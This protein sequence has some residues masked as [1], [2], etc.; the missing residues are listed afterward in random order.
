MAESLLFSVAESLVGKLA[1]TAVQKASEV[2]CVYDDV[3]GLKETVSFIKAV[4]LDAEQKPQKSNELRAWLR[5]I[6]R[7]F[8]DAEDII[9]DFECE[10][11]RK[12]V[13]NTYG[14]YTR[15]VRRFFSTSN[16]LVYRFRMAHHIKD[17]KKRLDKVAADRDKFGLQIKD[18]DTRVVHRRE[19]THSHV[20]ASDVIGREH[21]KEKIIELLLQDGT[22]A[23]S[24]SIIPIVGI[25]GLGKTTLAKL[26]FNDKIVDESFPLK[27]WVCV[28]D[29]FELEDMLRKIL[30]SAKDSSTPSSTLTRQESF[31]N[32]EMEQL[33]HLLTSKLAG[34]KFLLV[35]DD[36]WNED[37]VKWLKLKDLLQG[38]AEGSKVLVTT[39]SQSIAN[40]MGTNS[41]YGLQGLSEDDSLSLFVKWAFKEGE[42]TKY[43]ELLEIAKEIVEKCGGLPLAVRT[44]GS[45]LFLKVDKE[46]W[47]SV[48]DNEI[49]NLPS[50]EGDILP[51]LK[52]SYDQ[53]PS[54]LKPCF[55]CFSLCPKDYFFTDY[56]VTGLWE[57]L[58][59]LPSPNKN[60]T[61]ADVGIQILRELQSRSF[62]Q[63]FI[64]HGTFVQ[65]KLHDLVHDLTM[66]VAKDEFHRLNSCSQ[67]ISENARHLFFTKNDLLGQTSIPSGL[68]TIILPAGANNEAF[69]NTLVSRCKYLR[70]LN[71]SGSEYESLP[72][73]IGKLK[74]LRFLS[75]D[76]N[77]KLKRLPTSV[78]KLQNLQALYFGGCTKLKTLPRGIG[79]LISLR[80]LSVSTKQ[81]VFPDKEVAK[82]TSLEILTLSYCDNM[83]SLFQGVQLPTLRWLTIDSCG[84]LKS[85]PFHAT[86]NLESL[87][88]G[89]CSKL[90]MSK[91]LDNQIIELR[92]K[93]PHLCD[94]P[95]L[96][97]LPPWIQRYA[98]TLHSLNI[99]G[100]DNIKELPEWLPTLVC[101][102]TLIILYCPKLL[103]LPDDMLVSTNLEYLRIEYCPELC[104]RYQPEVGENWPK[105]SHIKRIY[106]G[107][108]E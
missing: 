70:F 51:A 16:P 84:S 60:K 59:F 95:Q 38:G 42:E 93:Y 49:W 48:R 23:R 46:E 29:D 47:V 89:G 80:E 106:I 85:L 99:E 90:E 37:R 52:L 27:M 10:T 75:L 3:Q 26:V 54:Y 31:K 107:E 94:L 78:C 62:L 77:E 13:V 9:D 74:H 71:L 41:S 53:L 1:S 50:K 17:I 88:I 103:S 101:L 15:K 30:K 4:L 55:A 43:P 76:S 66:Y 22:E 6:K 56:E 73:S 5:Q 86:P 64:D 61:L 58:G 81:S 104:R 102:K 33:Q 87:V 32:C 92:L 100:C 98:N 79:N 65:F 83:E 20:V 44:L 68:R 12:H 96:V 45:S 35:L 36:V 39:R 34:K 8:S 97:T 18:I 28:S 14:S 82:L 25:G 11:L 19:M 72:C 105:I 40:M 63:D 108:P 57:S 67:K 2:L 21:D 24:L 91:C 7:V 69:L